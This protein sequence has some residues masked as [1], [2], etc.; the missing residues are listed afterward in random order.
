MSES[1]SVGQQILNQR[2]L[3]EHCLTEEET[4]ELYASVAEYCDNN[5]NSSLADTLASCNAQLQYLGLEIVA[6]NLPNHENRSNDENSDSSKQNNS[7]SKHQRY[8]AMVNKFPDDIAKAAFQAH[9]FQPPQ[10]QAYVKAVLQKLCQGDDDGTA[11]RAVLLNLRNDLDKL[12]LAAA[13]DA[14]ERLLEEKWLTETGNNKRR[15]SNA[16]EIRLG[17]RAYCELS[18]MLTDEFGMDPNDLPQ[19]ILLR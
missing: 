13:E 17:A 16:A 6:V 1:L 5:D 3:A 2:L 8:Y 7:S 4:Q 12:P 15:G 10:Q 14:L 19:Q 9:L 11:T 18:Y